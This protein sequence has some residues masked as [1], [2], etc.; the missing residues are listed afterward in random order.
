M[1]QYSLDCCGYVEFAQTGS[2]KLSRVDVGN[3][4]HGCVDALQ[5]IRL[6]DQHRLSRVEVELKGIKRLSEGA[7][8]HNRRKKKKENL[9]AK[10]RIKESTHLHIDE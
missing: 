9:K 6:H 7:N 10:E 1:E 2:G 3:F 8:F 5:V 4:C